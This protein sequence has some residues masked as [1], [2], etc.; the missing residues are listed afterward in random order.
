MDEILDRHVG[1]EVWT[2][3]RRM[4]VASRISWL[5]RIPEEYRGAAEAV[6][7]TEGHVTSKQYAE[8]GAAVT[9]FFE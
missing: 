5:Q 8:L 3:Y 4:D 9:A 1:W 6:L 2:A 7:E